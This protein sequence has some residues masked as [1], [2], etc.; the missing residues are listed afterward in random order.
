MAIESRVIASDPLTGSQTIM[1]Y[2][3]DTE[4]ISLE[5]VQDVTDIVEHNKRLLNDAESGWKGDM[6]KIA[7]IP[8]SVYY[9]LKKRGIIDDPDDPKQAKFKKWLED[10]DNRVFRTKAGR[11]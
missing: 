3:H 8:L 1:H 7:S 9:D 10:P 11:L 6:H 4:D 2:D 5:E